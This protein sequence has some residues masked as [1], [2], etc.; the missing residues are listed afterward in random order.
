M[1]G[2][3][4][5]TVI[6]QPNPPASLDTCHISPSAFGSHLRTFSLVPEAKLA[7]PLSHLEKL[8]SL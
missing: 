8:L 1:E 2:K 7:L 4:T 3:L 5:G 6:F